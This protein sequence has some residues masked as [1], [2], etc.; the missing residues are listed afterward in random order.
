MRLQSNRWRFFTVLRELILAAVICLPL[1]ARAA[2][3]EG[4]IT[5]LDGDAFIYRGASRFLA[6]EGVHLEGGDIVETRPSSF[7]QIEFP[8]LSVIQFGPETRAMLSG[9]GPAA[10]QKPE[11]WLFVMNG[12]CKVVGAKARAEGRPGLEVRTRAFEMAATPA[13]VVFNERAADTTLFVERG[14]VRL[15]ERQASGSPV[16]VPL[17]AGDYYRRVAGA[18]GTVNSGSNRGFVE[19]VP[20]AFR[21]SLPLRLDRFR[22]KG[23]LPREAPDFT[24]ADVEAWLN[25]EPW[26]RRPFVQRWRVKA[27]DPAFRKELISSL[28]SHP[29]WDPVLFPEKYLNKEQLA[30]R[31]VRSR[32]AASEPSARPAAARP[33][34]EPASSPS[35][36]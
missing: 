17:K 11:D 18:R 14:E 26:L 33:A 32:A 21:D 1:C 20:R 12:W 8:D 36:Q 23:V 10:R 30:R 13:V 4:T 28:A 15:S 22:D 3:A 35:T 2:D 7:M 25:A 9:A 5:I 24:Y 27:K 19:S 16:G 31:A 34:A 6:V 29:E